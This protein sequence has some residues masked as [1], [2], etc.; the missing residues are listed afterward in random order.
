MTP[1]PIRCSCGSVQ[2]Y[3]ESAHRA[4]R[5]VCYC[6]DCQTFAG[7]LG[8]PEATMDT[9]GGTDIIATSPRFV[10]FTHGADQLKCMSLSSKGLLRWYSGCC[11]TPIANTPRNPKLSYVGLVRNC[12]AGSAS[13]VDAAF[14][15]ARGAINTGSATGKVQATPLATVG[16]LIKIFGNVGGSRL[17][18]KYRQNPFFR[19]GTS[20]PIVAPQV[21][22][23]AERKALRGA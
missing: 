12:L 9:R 16:A 10:R 15:P 20:E 5:A 7:F 3:L 1:F 17:T 13:E 21:L 19:P 8:K 14:G 11:R 18:G 22:S 4:S 2:G 23:L 6:R